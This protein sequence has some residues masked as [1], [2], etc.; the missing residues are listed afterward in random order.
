MRADTILINAVM[1]G[2]PLR[3]PTQEVAVAGGRVLGVGKG[4]AA[5]RDMASGAQIVDCC[6]G[7]VLPGFVD[8][9]LHFFS[10]V[11]SLLA[12]DLRPQNGVQSIADIQSALRR[13]ADRIPP[14]QWLRGRG[15]DDFRLNGRRHPNRL[16]LDAAVPNHPVKLTH[17]SLH[18]HVLNSLA[19]KLLG[20]DRNT[21][22]P[23]GGMIDRDPVTGDPTGILYEM[24]EMLA[25]RVPRWTAKTFE[26]GVKRAAQ[27]LAASGITA[28]LDASPT[29]DSS[30]PDLF[31]EY[32]A[33]RLVA[34]RVAMMMGPG[35][36]AELGRR[37]SASGNDD[38]V[39]IWGIKVIL[40]RTTGALR[41]GRDE[42]ADTVQKVHEF[43]W[44]VAIH[45]VEEETVEAALSAFETVPSVARGSRKTGDRIE[46]G[47]VC[48][49]HLARRMAA[50]GISVTT[51]PSFIHFHGDRYLE[52]VHPEQLPHLY[53]LATLIRGG[54][55]VA[56]SSDCPLVPP[57][58]LM[59]IYSAVTRR[60]RS[61]AVVSPGQEIPVKDAVAMYTT[62]AARAV[63]LDFYTTSLATG[64]AADL[65][66][67]SDDPL[68]VPPD[69][70]KHIEVRLTM[71]AGEIVWRSASL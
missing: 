29:V 39:A 59:G 63:G 6:G 65:V 47:S 42:L 69:S 61:G 27:E 23:P 55:A 20:I 8:A 13:K 70:L 5:D 48:P 40:D 25:R 35:A 46:H 14:G 56:G 10:F 45:A 3:P 4:L 19:L 34:Q 30:R 50:L 26:G 41:P 53:P 2:D 33:K 15:Y 67:L 66:V 22:D 37:D 54:V 49:P 60:A 12:A 36:L 9:H 7:A 38:E 71:I 58:P 32:K 21:Q 18:A 64:Q 24:G 17:R 43:G 44:P 62:S 1:P 57:S 16:D 51:Q 68:A 31:R 11:D 52:S 28:F